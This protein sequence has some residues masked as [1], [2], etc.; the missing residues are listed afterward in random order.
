MQLHSLLGRE[1]H[2]GKS[3]VRKRGL[4]SS[5]VGLVSTLVHCSN[6]H[7]LNA[8]TR[9][10]AMLNQKKMELLLLASVL[11]QSVCGTKVSEWLNHE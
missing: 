6:M 2:P 11:D 8:R 3:C 7:L 1:T 4:D 10:G 9:E 5:N